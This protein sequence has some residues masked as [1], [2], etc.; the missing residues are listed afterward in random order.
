[1][2]KNGKEINENKK[3][4]KPIKEH[5]ENKKLLKATKNEVE[6][7]KLNKLIHED[8]IE[9]LE[10]SPVP[11]ESKARRTRSKTNHIQD[12]KTIPTIAIT[13]ADN[14]NELSNKTK[15]ESV[16]TDTNS[17]LPE[18]IITNT[19]KSRGNK[20]DSNNNESKENKKKMGKQKKEKNK[21]KEKP[22]LDLDKHCG[23]LGANGQACMRLITCKA[24]TVVLKKAVF[25]RSKTYQELVALHQKNNAKIKG[26]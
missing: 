23:V 11:E 22:V 18:S 13:K 26:K 3:H 17:L 12:S 4:V 20:K 15:E 2:S 1:M 7:K 25:G 8:I 5:G 19:S 21:V 6:N 9:D 16:V 24:H 10:S 14:F